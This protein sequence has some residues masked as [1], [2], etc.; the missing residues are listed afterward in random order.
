MTITTGDA[1]VLYPVWPAP[2]V[3][4]SDGAYG[5]GGF[6][7]DPPT[8][9]GLTSW[10]EPHA[11][12]WARHAGPGT[13]LW[14]WNTEIG[15]ATVHPLLERHGWSY[16]GL[17]TWD[18]GLAHIAGNCNTKTLRQYPVVTEVCAHYVREARLPLGGLRMPPSQR[19]LPLQF[20]LR[21]EWERTGLP[22]TRA[23]EAC[24]VRDA[25]TRKYLTTC[26]LW[27][28]PP[29]R[30]FEQLSA[31]ANEHGA[32]AG[33]PYFSRDG[34]APITAQEWEALRAPFKCQAGVTNVWH[35]PAVRGAERV[36]DAAGRVVHGNQKPLRLMEQIL[37]ASSDPDDVVW[38]PF[39]GLCTAT[40]AAARLGRRGFAAE[41]QPAMAEAAR[42]RLIDATLSRLAAHDN[43]M[44]LGH[45]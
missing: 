29:A 15:W 31:Y 20:W 38:E 5:I 16:R 23:N 22:L 36:K 1:L 25:A 7:G 37:A 14:F 10:Y 26:H 45:E 6:P 18:K 40:V 44:G 4:V 33:R 9:V 3:I 2:K 28:C 43:A 27:Y 24:G 11:E 41:V 8:V 21:A 39:G 42:H 32:S 12:A 35:E 13:T 19:L 17:N 30:V 34:V